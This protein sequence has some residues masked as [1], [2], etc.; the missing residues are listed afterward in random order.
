MARHWRILAGSGIG[1]MLLLAAGCQDTSSPATS[2]TSP[3]TVDSISGP[4]G[5]DVFADVTAQTGINFTYRNG[6]EADHYAII[7]SLGG[8]VALIDYDQDG[9]LDIFLPGGGYYEGKKV[10]GYPCRLYR[11]LGQFRF[12]DVTAAVGLDNISFPYSHGAAAFDYDC[13]GWPDLLITG[14]NR[15]VLL[16][17]VP[18]EAGGRRFV[19]V[20]HAAG[21]RDRLWST[22]AAWGDLDGDGYPEIFVAH[23]GDWGFDTNHPTDCTYDGKTRDV[24]QPR[25]FKPLPHTLYRNNRDGT[26]SD[27][28]E[29]CKI[30]KDG[31]GIGVI[32]VDINN[33]GR[34]DIYVANDTD[35]NHLYVN[36][37]QTGQIVLEETALFAGAARD[38]RG[39]AN[40]SMGLDAADYNRSGLASLIVT[41]YENELPA[42]YKNRST[43]KQIRFLYDTM[44]SGLAVIGGTYVSWGV[45]FFDFD[46]DGWPD[47]FIV[48]GHAIRHPIK[49]DR[50]QKPQLL[51]NVQGRFRVVTSQ[52]GSYCLQPHNARGAAFGDL[53][54]DGRIDV[55]VSH[56]NE[57]VAVLRNVYPARDHH[58]IGLHLRS[59]KNADTVGTRVVLETPQ[60]KQTAFVKGGASYASTNDPRLHFGLGQDSQIQRLTI[61]WASGRVQE[62]NG[63]QPDAYWAIT[64]GESSP[65]RLVYPVPTVAASSVP[66]SAIPS[67]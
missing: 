53:D 26:F 61:Y 41:N 63:V 31:K 40:G 5:P 23:Y 56:L 35:D 52:G 43:D 22:S 4:T 18:D 51:R 20:T 13:D 48:S 34:P 24:C 65:Q 15:L 7:E 8:G 57:P 27:V 50:R 21:L 59:R 30:R 33:D 47:L 55:V 17:N 29:A 45:G 66:T 67:H 49:L 6:E 62:V 19:D 28:S 3:A 12:Q 9:L 11:N 25:R 46:N 54:N 42:L 60:G 1:W 16:K 58:W 37:S 10:L 44:P 2:P 14:Y 36:R 38:D 64:E 39:I 32:M